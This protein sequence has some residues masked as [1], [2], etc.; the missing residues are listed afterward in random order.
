MQVFTIELNTKN[1]QNVYEKVF[2]SSLEV[3][4]NIL[5]ITE[6]QSGKELSLPLTSVKFWFEMEIKEQKEV[7]AEESEKK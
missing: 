5:V 1:I 7:P 2:A 6:Q 3:K 4:D